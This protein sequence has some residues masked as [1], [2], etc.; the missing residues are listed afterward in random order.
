VL[1]HL[2]EEETVQHITHAQHFLEMG[3][4]LLRENPATSPEASGLVGHN[5]G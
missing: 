3:E 5:E 2:T 1:S 4:K